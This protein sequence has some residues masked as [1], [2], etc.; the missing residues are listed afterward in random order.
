M[1]RNKKIK[2][3]CFVS[4]SADVAAENSSEGSLSDRG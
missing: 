4:N 1:H 3:G 2:T